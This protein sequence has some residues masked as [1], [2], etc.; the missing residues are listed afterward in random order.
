MD[1]HL[2]IRKEIKTDVIFCLSETEIY[3]MTLA[4]QNDANRMVEEFQVILHY[5]LPRRTSST[6]RIYSLAL[7]NMLCNLANYHL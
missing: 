7:I 3:A 2:N 5:Q 1:Q 4:M 6:N